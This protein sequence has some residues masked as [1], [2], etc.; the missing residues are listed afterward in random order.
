MFESE[1]AIVRMMKLKV[2]GYLSKNIKVEDM[3]SALEAIA[4]KG[5]YYTDEVA[6]IMAKAASC[7]LVNCCATAKKFAQA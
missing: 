2:K 4:N 3:H 5:F 1:K 7:I 6:G